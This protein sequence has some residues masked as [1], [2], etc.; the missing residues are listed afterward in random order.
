MFSYFIKFELDNLGSVGQ[1]KFYKYLCLRLII[2][3]FKL[4][5]QHLMI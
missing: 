1:L 2:K 3:V 4:K 5:I